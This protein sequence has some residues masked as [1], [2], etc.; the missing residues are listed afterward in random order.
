MLT[1]ILTSRGT[2]GVN[3]DVEVDVDSGCV[4]TGFHV[5]GP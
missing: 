2:V 4:Q 5:T 3:I 1:A